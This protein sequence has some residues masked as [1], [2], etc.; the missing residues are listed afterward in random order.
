MRSLEESH[1][2]LEKEAK[3][4]RD[5][6]NITSVE[7]DKFKEENLRYKISMEEREKHSKNFEEQLRLLGQY[8]EV[9]SNFV[10]I[11]NIMKIK[12]DDNSWTKINFLE[13]INGKFQFY[14]KT[15]LTTRLNK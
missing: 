11:M 8:G 3:T 1:K 4:L 12:D 15:S 13:K 10:K 9:D 7:R 5:D 14:I 2:Y 6:L